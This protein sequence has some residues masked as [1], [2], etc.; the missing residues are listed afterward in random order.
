M[1]RRSESC[2]AEAYA[3]YREWFPRHIACPDVPEEGQLRFGFARK[4]AD[5]GRFRSSKP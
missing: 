1:P 2:S 5:M 4:P 3:S